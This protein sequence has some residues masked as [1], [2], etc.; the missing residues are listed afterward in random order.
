MGAAAAVLLAACGGSEESGPAKAT[1][2]K[3]V[4]TT[5]RAVPGGIYPQSNAADIS[6]MDIVA[7]GTM[8]TSLISGWAYSRFLQWKP[9][10]NAPADGSIEG[11]AIQSYEIAP[12][13]QQ[14]TLKVREALWDSRPP[15]SSRPVNSADIAYSWQRYGR[16]GARR[17]DVLNRLNR[18]SP[19]LDEVQTPDD[20]TVVLKLAFADRIAPG[21]LANFTILVPV[22]A[23][24]KFDLKN[25][26]RGTG[27]WM[28]SDYR[29]SV[30]I[31]HRKNP[32]W[33]R[34]DRP[35]LEGFDTFFVPEYATALSQFE[36][37]KTWNH[38]TRTE[39]IIRVKRDHQD[40]LMF[41]GDYSVQLPIVSF[42][43]DANS[44]FKDERV[45][46]AAS[47]A[48]D[49]PLFIETFYNTK[50]FE[51]AGLPNEIRYASHL[52]EGWDGYWLSPQSNEFGPNAKYL[53]HDPAEGRKLLAAA[54]YPNGVD[55]ELTYSTNNTY[56]ADFPKKQEVYIQ[57]WRDVGLRVNPNVQDHQS[58]VLARYAMEPNRAFKGMV[59]TIKSG[60]MEPA[61][62]LSGIYLG[63]G[64]TSAMPKSLDPTLEDMLLKGRGEPDLAKRRNLVLETQ[65]YLAKTMWAIPNPGSTAP[66]TLAWPWVG[67][68]GVVRTWPGGGNV[69]A[70]VNPVLWLDKT[71]LKA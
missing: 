33:H 30:S 19:F 59:S 10:F 35:F 46:Q 42:G 14:I 61:A 6:T 60:T 26:A 50:A 39:D 3:P 2:T 38:V 44:I 17:I 21:I 48:I 34:K 47:L 49:R 55:S 64:A 9:G 52:A 20:R 1:L 68:Q 65:R 25:T 62:V 43:F 51:E 32:N 4:D 40:L 71:K 29:Q 69:A 66:I 53:K 67:N 36:A 13:G 11:N 18:A 28:I 24:D 15:T 41:A 58:V 7:D 22:E 8:G 31:S 45:R 23:E 37:G 57:M 70:Q 56:G 63:G 54:G 5:A 16:V 27:P 12:D